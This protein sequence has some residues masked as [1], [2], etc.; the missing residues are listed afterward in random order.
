MKGK[1]KVLLLVSVTI[2]MLIDYTEVFTQEAE[3]DIFSGSP[4]YVKYVGDLNRRGNVK[5]ATEAFDLLLISRRGNVKY[6]AVST[7]F[8]KEKGKPDDYYAPW[9]AND[10]DKNTVWAEGVKGDGI[11]EKIYIM[12]EW[13]LNYKPFKPVTINFNIIN[14][15]AASEGLFNSNNRVKKAKLTIY[16][17][18]LDCI[19]GSTGRMSERIT[20]LVSNYKIINLPDTSAVQNIQIKIPP[21]EEIDTTN[22]CCCTNGC[23]MAEL[24][25]LEV[26]K[27]T[28]YSDTCIS[29]FNFKEIIQDI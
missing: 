5:N 9:R 28:K 4:K 26:Y 25:I 22:D 17:A 29:E 19:G 2:L 12:Q 11:G 7:S 13:E 27:G 10:K 23:F 6:S 3:E 8:L 15:C 16:Q 21:Y 18:E 24:E 14:G 20:D 1:F